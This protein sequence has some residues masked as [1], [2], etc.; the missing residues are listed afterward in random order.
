MRAALA[1]AG[2][3]EGR[4]SP[5]PP[6]GCVLVKHGEIVGKGWHDRLGGLHAEAMAL[7]DA[8]EAAR[9]A[10][11]YVTLSP[12]TTHGRQPP[13]SAAL[14][15]AGVAEV[16]V[17]ADDPNPKN[18]SGVDLLRAAG[19]PARSG[20]LREEAEYLARGFFKTMRRGLPW[21]TFKYAMT[22]DGKIATG[23]GD[24]R[25]IS[26]PASRE[27]V[28]DQRSRHDAIL[29][30]SGTALTDDPLLTVRDPVLARR[31]GAAH[32]Q[33][34]RVVADSRCRMPTDAK[35]LQSD[36]EPGGDVLVAC[37]QSAP[38]ERIRALT[39]AGAEVLPL[40]SGDGHVPLGLLMEELARRGIGM[41]YLEGGSGLAAGMLREGL[42]DE[43]ITFMAP[44]LIGGAGAPG[45]VG[46]IGVER[47]ADALLL[48]IREYRQAGDDMMIRAAI[49]AKTR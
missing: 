41:V 23:T 33:P 3:G 26:G 18:C 20:L 6:V 35:M 1:L 44:K 29:V 16:I 17:A 40:P 42:V 9:G 22:M 34:L 10:T 27:I 15:N 32:P 7:R 8:G 5:N 25:W 43:V 39:D 13:C 2:N 19:I 37:V 46:D 47:L 12:C 14:I 4:V 31:G 36:C 24:S 48:D 45:P 38:G 30:G 21:V 28:Q 49:K 11:A